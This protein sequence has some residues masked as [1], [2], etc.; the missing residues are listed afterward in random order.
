MG[1]KQ[2]QTF[3]SPLAL[4]DLTPS[5]LFSSAVQV[6][7]EH[8]LCINIH[9]PAKQRLFSGVRPRLE[10][11]GRYTHKSNATKDALTG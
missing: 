3:L 6:F 5:F 2:E 10:G 8:I 9:R 1:R 11:W 4:A 7:I